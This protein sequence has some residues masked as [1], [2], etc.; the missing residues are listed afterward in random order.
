M[1]RTLCAP[2]WPGSCSCSSFEL[3][4][5]RCTASGHCPSVTSLVWILRL[6]AAATA[7]I[8]RLTGLRLTL[9]CQTSVSADELSAV[10]S[11]VSGLE[12]LVLMHIQ[13]APLLDFKAQ[14]N[15]TSMSMFWPQLSTGDACEPLRQL[16][17]LRELRFTHCNSC[18]AAAVTTVCTGAA[19][20]DSL[21]FAAAQ[22][23]RL[24][25]VLPRLSL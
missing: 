13:P 19:R 15:L 8:S 10:L 9:L 25:E 11:S 3:L 16:P 22:V 21:P 4:D 5:M 7:Q 18:A 2:A 14:T 1:G 17:A 20:V 6:G 23:G 24:T 12:S